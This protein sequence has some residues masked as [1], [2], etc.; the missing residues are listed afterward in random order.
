MARSRVTFVLT[1]LFIPIFACWLA[2]RVHNF[3]PAIEWEPWLRNGI[4]ISVV[5]NLIWLFLKAVIP[6]EFNR[7]ALVAVVTNSLGVFL[8]YLA[9]LTVMYS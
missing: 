4:L 2:L 3:Q 6:N 1:C 8:I 7:I 9:Y 5:L